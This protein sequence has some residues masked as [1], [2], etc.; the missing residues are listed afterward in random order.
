VSRR[1]GV[2]PYASAPAPQSKSLSTHANTGG[3][4]MRT[5]IAKDGT[6]IYYKDYS[7]GQPI[8]FSHGWPLTADAL[9]DQMFFLASRGYRCI[10]ADRRGHGRSIQPRIGN[11]WDTYADD[12]AALVQTPDLKNVEGLHFPRATAQQSTHPLQ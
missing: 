7:S 4:A 3:N 6:E 11:D 8:V 10:A 2:D 9:E 1:C 5:L 12:L